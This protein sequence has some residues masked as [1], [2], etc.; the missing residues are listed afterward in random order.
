MGFELSLSESSTATLVSTDTQLIPTSGLTPAAQQEALEKLSQIQGVLNARESPT[1]SGLIVNFVPS[2]TS[3]QQLNEVVAS[4]TTL[5]TPTPSSPVQKG[6]TLSPSHSTRGGVALLKLTIKGMT[7]HSC[8]TTIEGKI[9][10]LKGIEKIKGDVLDPLTNY[11]TSLSELKMIILLYYEGT[12]LLQ[13]TD[14]MLL[15]MSGCL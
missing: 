9:G 13:I 6:P 10:K 2:L 12:Q 15:F 7:C 1:K 8:T 3:V 5:E 14:V 4:I 11:I